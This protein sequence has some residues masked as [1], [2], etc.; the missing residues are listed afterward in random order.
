[1]IYYFSG[2]GNSK[3]V[4]EMLASELNDQANT[5]VQVDQ[6]SQD[7]TIIIVS[8]IYAWLVPEIVMDFMRNLNL[9]SHQSLYLVVTCGDNVGRAI[10]RLKREVRLDGAYSIAMP[11]NYVIGFDVDPELEQT[12]KILAARGQVD[13]I[14]EDI[15]QG[16]RVERINKGRF[17]QYFGSFAGTM[18]QRFART[19]KPFYVQEQCISCSMCADECPVHA[20]EMV[21]G[22]PVW[23]KSTCQMCLKC[24]HTCPVEA[25]QY[26][27]STLNKG[28]YTYE[29]WSQSHRD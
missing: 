26:G 6:I 7:K 22:K 24:L 21:D 20:I 14:A 3:Y 2:T 11:N 10:D 19:T 28:R 18:F 5:L 27:R 15:R 9:Q 1:M 29:K 17:A 4:A 12:A 23:V 8:P 16:L 25:I 13:Q